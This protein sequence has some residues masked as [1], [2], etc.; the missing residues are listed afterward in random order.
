MTLGGTYATSD[1]L[2]GYLGQATADTTD[3]TRITDALNSAS[4]SIEKYCHRQFNA[5]GTVSAR[6][7]Y[8]DSYACAVV[9][10][11]STT[12]GLIIATDTNGDGV[13][14]TTWATTDYQ[15][16]PLNGIV[17]GESGWPSWRIRAVGNNW[18]PCVL[19]GTQIAPLQVTADWGWA[20]VPANVKQACL[21]L[22]SH[23]FRLAGAPFGVAGFDQFGPIRVKTLPQVVELL[24]PYVL[25]PVLV[26]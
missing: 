2:K 7:Y 12:T 22:A 4:R 5:A 23:Y 17:D 6:V 20:T 1:E 3:N 16:E 8:P 13:Y 14:E 9:D 15:L 21:I 19:Y 10:D 26:A 18:F 24:Q 25:N 11:I